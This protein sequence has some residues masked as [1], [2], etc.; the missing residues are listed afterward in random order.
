MGKR[1]LNFHTSS[2]RAD[3]NR[4]PGN[5][6][7]NV[8]ARPLFILG[9]LLVIDG[10]ISLSFSSIAIGVIGLIA[11]LGIQHNGE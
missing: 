1:I 2:W 11:G 5:L 9:A 4:H 8:I 7:L 6:A 10:L 3:N